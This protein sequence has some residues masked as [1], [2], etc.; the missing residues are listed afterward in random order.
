[1]LSYFVM[2]GS[3]DFLLHVAVADNDQLSSSSSTASL[4]GAKSCTC[5]P[6]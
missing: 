4:S 6:R 3:N 2:S 5:V 1:M